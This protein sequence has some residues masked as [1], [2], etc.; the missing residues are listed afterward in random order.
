MPLVGWSTPRTASGAVEDHLGL[1]F[2]V[3]EDQKHRCREWDCGTVVGQLYPS[4]FKFWCSH[5][6]MDFFQNFQ[7]KRIRARLVVLH[8]SHALEAREPPNLFFACVRC[9]RLCT[10]GVSVKCA[11]CVRPKLYPIKKTLV[12]IQSCSASI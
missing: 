9:T 5:L 11:G 10:R 2:A 8:V 1:R 3:R 4:G 6:F 12:P 7:V